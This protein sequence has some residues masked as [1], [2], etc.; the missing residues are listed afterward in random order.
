[1]VTTDQLLTLWH[2]AV[3]NVIIIQVINHF[4]VVQYIYY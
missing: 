4:Y 1:V 2:T 3:G